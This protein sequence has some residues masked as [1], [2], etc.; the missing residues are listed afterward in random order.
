MKTVFVSGVALM[1]AENH[2]LLAQRPKGKSFEGMWEFPGGKI[3]PGETAEETAIR[4]MQEELGVTIK[5]HDLEPF[6]FVSIKYDDFAFVMVLYIARKWQGKLVGR[7][8]QAFEWT[9]IGNLHTYPVPEA[10]A[11][12]IKKLQ[13]D[14]ESLIIKE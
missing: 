2:I 12:I 8:G 11:P 5:P 14:F 4:E 3:D 13:A 1:N 7:E 6:T 9:P 10:D